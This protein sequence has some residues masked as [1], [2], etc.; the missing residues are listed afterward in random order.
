MS[1]PLYD[2]V[3]CSLL[4]KAFAAARQVNFQ[5][6]DVNGDEKHFNE[7]KHHWSIPEYQEL[8][9]FPHMKL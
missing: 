1:E 6:V 9:L 8:G 3:V 7:P 5:D 2:N 4:P